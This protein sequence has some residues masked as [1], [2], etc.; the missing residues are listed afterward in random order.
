MAGAAIN[1]SATSA[2]KLASNIILFIC[3]SLFLSSPFGV[4]A[5]TSP[6]A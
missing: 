2:T 4:L 1:I 6:P 3:S 5:R